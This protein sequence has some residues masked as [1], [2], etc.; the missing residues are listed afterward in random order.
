MNEPNDR[1]AL[2]NRLRLVKE[3]NDLLHKMWSVVTALAWLVTENDDEKM[4]RLKA[5]EWML[6]NDR[7]KSQTERNEQWRA[8][9][10]STQREVEQGRADLPQLGRSPRKILQRPN[11]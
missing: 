4:R 7:P 9:L 5:M 1:N 8:W 6:N 2:Y 11:F 3:Q 10:I